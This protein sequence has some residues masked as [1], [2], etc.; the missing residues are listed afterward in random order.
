[1]TDLF[2]K[3]SA[4]EQEWWGTICELRNDQEPLA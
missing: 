4:E 2:S 3:L 1:M